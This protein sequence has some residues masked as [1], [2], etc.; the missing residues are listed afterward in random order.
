[1]NLSVV[2]KNTFLLNETKVFYVNL[3]Q[4]HYELQYLFCG[5]LYN[6]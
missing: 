1:M 4:C 6:H 2:L 5:A 3:L